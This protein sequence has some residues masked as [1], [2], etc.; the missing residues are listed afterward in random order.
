[1]ELS[2][3]DLALGMDCD[4]GL[5]WPKIYW[6]PLGGVEGGRIELVSGQ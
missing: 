4:I 5:G 2:E 6:A 1:V 3:W